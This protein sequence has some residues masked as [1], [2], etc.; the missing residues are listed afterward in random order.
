MN[1]MGIDYR[2]ICCFFLCVV[3]FGVVRVRGNG[4]QAGQYNFLKINRSVSLLKYRF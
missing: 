3:Q 2:R 1:K 4:D